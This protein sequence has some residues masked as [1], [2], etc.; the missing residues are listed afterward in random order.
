MEKLKSQLETTQH[1]LASAKE[2]W[3]EKYMNEASKAKEAI[4]KNSE[5]E[6]LLSKQKLEVCIC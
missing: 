1:E 4:K 6:L 3:S 5:L 2:E